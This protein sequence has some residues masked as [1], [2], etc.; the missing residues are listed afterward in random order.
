MLV[1]NAQ[2][3]LLAGELEVLSGRKSLAK[4]ESPAGQVGPQ[5]I[6]CL[7]VRATD[8]FH[9]PSYFLVA[10]PTDL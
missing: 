4:G 2:D 1:V 7:E 9:A 10:S 8:L 3:P 6:C 5:P